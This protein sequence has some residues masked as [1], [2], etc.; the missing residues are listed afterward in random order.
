MADFMTD[1][2]YTF[3]VCHFGMCGIAFA[4]DLIL[5]VRG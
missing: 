1:I 3:L 5:K 4:I 2:I